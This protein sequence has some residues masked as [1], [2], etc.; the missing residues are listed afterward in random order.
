MSQSKITKLR[1]DHE[2]NITSITIYQIPRHEKYN[3]TDSQSRLTRIYKKIP[4]FFSL[5]R[6]KVR[7]IINGPTYPTPSCNFKLQRISSRT[8]IQSVLL[9]DSLIGFPNGFA[10]C[11]T[12]LSHLICP[13]NIRLKFSLFS[14]SRASGL[15]KMDWKNL[16]WRSCGIMPRA[17]ELYIANEGNG[18]NGHNHYFYT[19][20]YTCYSLLFIS[21]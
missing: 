7:R 10:F 12:M 6:E 20:H 1:K 19:Y 8:L 21:Q 16:R 9:F 14:P 17:I 11:F 4:I 13:I 5:I 2:F 3:I 18:D 15:L